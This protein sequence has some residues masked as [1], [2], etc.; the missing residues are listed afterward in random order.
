[1][2]V[3]QSAMYVPVDA[4][5]WLGRCYT[6]QCPQSQLLPSDALTDSNRRS[7]HAYRVK[8][9]SLAPSRH[10]NSFH[11]WAGVSHELLNKENQLNIVSDDHIRR[12]DQLSANVSAEIDGTTVSASAK[13]EFSSTSTSGKGKA[14]HQLKFVSR[15]FSLELDR[16][17]AASRF[18]EVSAVSP[19]DPNMY[20]N[21]FITKIFYGGSFTLEMDQENYEKYTSSGVTFAIDAKASL[22]AV[23]AGASAGVG[24]TR[25]RGLRSFSCNVAVKGGPASFKTMKFVNMAIEDILHKV[26]A[27]H[28]MLSKDSNLAVP[29]QI[30]VQTHK[31]HQ[32]KSLQR[33]FEEEATSRISIVDDQLSMYSSVAWGQK[34][35]LLLLADRDKLIKEREKSASE[36]LRMRMRVADLEAKETASASLIAERNGRIK[37]LE[38][39]AETALLITKDMEARVAK[40]E[41]KEASVIKDIVDALRQS[42]V[43][44]PYCD[45]PVAEAIVLGKD[46]KYA[47]YAKI[48]KD[49]GK[50]KGD[51]GIEAIGWWALGRANPTVADKQKCFVHALSL[52]PRFGCSWCALGELAAAF[53]PAVV[54][55]ENKVYSEQQCYVQALQVSPEYAYAWKRL[56]YTLNNKAQ[57]MV[58]GVACNAEMCKSSMEHFDNSMVIERRRLGSLLSIPTF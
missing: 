13:A 27:W 45:T 50:D 53:V 55:I 37:S 19:D 29:L 31:E 54:T 21:G 58:N 28:T 32:D 7:V 23:E 14:N 18:Y 30:Y 51:K 38:D 8:W 41:T 25:E 44:F 1:M 36:E 22:F 12:Q 49:Y 16:L 35:V 34:G 4:G 24:V 43:K 33:C 9:D 56:Y 48:A 52:D 46:G 15:Q 17:D 42:D 57:V 3:C 10:G 40:L 26:N 47:T 39:S 20:G 2:G 6:L 11:V 5:S